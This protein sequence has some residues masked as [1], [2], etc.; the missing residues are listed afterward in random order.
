MQIASSITAW[1]KSTFEEC[2]IKLDSFMIDILDKCETH[3]YVAFM[4]PYDTF[5]RKIGITKAL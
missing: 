2:K 4:T 3:Q 5:R 1:G